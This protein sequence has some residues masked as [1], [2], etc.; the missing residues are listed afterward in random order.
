MTHSFIKTGARVWALA[1]AA[2]LPITSQAQQAADASPLTNSVVKVFSTARL[3]DPFKPWAK[4]G[5]RDSTGSG[6]VIE[7]NRILTNAHVVSYASQVQVQGSGS[8]DRLNASVVAVAPGI[9]LAVLKLE[10]ESFFRRHPPLARA[11]ALPA[12]KDA[13]LAYGFPTGGSSLSITK[14]IVSRIEYATYN[15]PVSGLR[16]QIDAAINPGNSGGPAIAEDK[17]IGLAF[18]GVPGAQSIGYIIPNTEIELFLKDIDDGKYDGKSFLQDDLQ[19]LE[20]S[21]LRK[22]LKLDAS[23]KGMVVN[24]PYKDDAA[25]PLKKWDVITH[26]GDAAVDDQGMVKSGAD[27]R[28][29][30]RYQVQKAVVNGTLPLTVWRAGQSIKVA[31]PVDPERPMMIPDLKGD[32]PPY[33]V[34]GPIVFSKATLQFVSFMNAGSSMAAFSTIRSPL[35][36]LRSASP[37]P[38]REELVVIASPFFPHRLSTGYNNA[39]AMVIRSVNG[40]P[41]R[42]LRH[43]VAQLRDMKEEFVNFETDNRG[44]ETLVFAHKEMVAASEDILN[45]NSVRAQGSPELMELWQ[46]KVAQ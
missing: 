18:A 45:D 22:Y 21:A 1:V 3:P 2:L 42:S 40:T 23:V 36:T 38:E 12:I 32:Y 10:D 15:A 37:T 13:V 14:G 8:G 44:G 28:L 20:N 7:G 39:T 11:T 29:N 43:L 46:G 19:R 24:R 41:V 6:V 33:F 16:I 31:L 17:M 34:Y 30:M 35:V 26:V 27:L 9:D 25:Y 5:P 4:Q